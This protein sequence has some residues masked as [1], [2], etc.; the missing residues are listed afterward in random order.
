[1]SDEPF[2]VLFLCTGNS[3]RSILAEAILAREG[4]GRFN[5]FSAGSHPIGEVNPY[6]LELLNNLDFR[7]DD[8]HSKSW[9]GFAG[10]DAHGMADFCS[11]ATE[12]AHRFDD[13]AAR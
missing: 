2:N 4:A 10:D 6:A 5:A 3:A 11:P 13:L 1:M 7:T 8:F 12:L 9:D